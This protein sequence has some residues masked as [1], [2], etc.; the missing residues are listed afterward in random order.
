MST[1]FEPT[2]VP[3][4]V[5]K[6]LAAQVVMTNANQYYD[7]PAVALT[8]GTWILTGTVTCEDPA[9]SGGVNTAQL[10]DGATVAA[11]TSANNNPA[12]NPS[13]LSLAAVVVLAVAATWKIS[14]AKAQP[15]GRISA[16]AAANGVGNNASTLTAVQ[17]A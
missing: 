14:V 10:W 1:Y 6:Q 9:V 2:F 16:A 12:G 17:I 13:S 7:G 11:S 4:V 3:V 15:N 5:S 8:P